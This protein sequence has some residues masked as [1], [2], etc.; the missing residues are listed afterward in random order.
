MNQGKKITELEKAASVPDGSSYIVEM[1]DGT[2]TKRVLHEDMVK[3]V[4]SS[5]PLGETA[6]LETRNRDNFVGAINEL[7]R[8]MALGGI[9]Y[10][11][12][13]D[14]E[15][16]YERLDAVF[17]E[18]ST[19]VAMKDG[20][21]GPP[22]ADV[23]NWQYLAKGFMEG[24]LLAKS[25]LVN[26]LLATEPGNPLDAVQGKALADMISGI[27]GNLSHV[28][29]IIHSTTL[30][31]EAKV[32]AVYGG[33]KW[34]KIEGR[35]LLGASSTYKV[36][37]IGG[38]AKHTLTTAEMPRHRHTIRVETSFH[39]ASGGSIEQAW[40]VNANSVDTTPADETAGGG[41]AHNNMPPYKAVY[42]WERTA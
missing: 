40:A 31:T 5:L 17:Y 3:S 23:A 35:F 41:G 4:G 24:Y 30:N 37:A 34:L 38:E 6:E 42:I 13:Y 14:P 9:A 28:G 8:K 15:A 29:M 2:G 32:I 18:G 21:E 39:P 11:G 12:A 10:K 25:Q 36:N 20:P 1:G 7:V 16:E 33:T 26:N 22:T 19:F 27:N